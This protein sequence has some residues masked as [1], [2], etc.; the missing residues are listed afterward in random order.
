MVSGAFGLQRKAGSILI[1]FLDKGK[2]DSVSPLAAAETAASGGRLDLHTWGCKNKVLVLTKGFNDWEK[3]ALVLVAVQISGS[4][5][6][7]RFYQILLWI[8]HKHLSLLS[9]QQSPRRKQCLCRTGSLG[10]CWRKLCWATLHKLTS[11]RAFQCLIS[12]LFR[13]RQDRMCLT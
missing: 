13:A 9:L 3:V 8:L 7:H 12:S 5:N 4:F 1:F 10:S 6:L 11:H 2:L